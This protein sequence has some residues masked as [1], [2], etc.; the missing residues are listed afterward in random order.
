MSFSSNLKYFRKKRGLKQSELAN[1]L[2]VSQQS[3]AK[4][5]N[6]KSEP[7]IS[8]ISDI[9]EKLNCSVNDLLSGKYMTDDLLVR[10]SFY[11][12]LHTKGNSSDFEAPYRIAVRET[13]DLSMANFIKVCNNMDEATL[14]RIHSILFSIRKLQDNQFLS[15]S[16]KQQLFECVTALIGRVEIFAD[17]IR[18]APENQV[19]DYSKHNKR[20]TTGEIESLK[21]IIGIMLPAVNP[22]INRGI[23][24]PFYE[25]PVSAGVGSWLSDDTPTEWITLPRNDTTESADMILEIRGDSMQPRFYNGDKVLVKSSESIMEGEIGV[26]VLNGESFIKKMGKGCLISLNPSY[27][28]IKIGS[29]DDIHCVGRVIDRV[30]LN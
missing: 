11:E 1:L 19:F 2:H 10:P 28:P 29:F 15:A 18:Y 25:T 3:I 17:E 6:G 8:T 24:I 20:F 4:W 13:H 23:V 9:A 7:N 22:T 12:V 27:E 5:E 30:V 14:S 16:D 21:E 26:F